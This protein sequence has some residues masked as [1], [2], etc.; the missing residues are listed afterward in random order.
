MPFTP[1]QQQDLDETFNEYFASADFSLSKVNLHVKQ[2]FWTFDNRNTIDG[3]TRPESRDE[4]VNT[5]VSTI[6]GNTQLGERWDLSAGYT[7]A[8]SDGRADLETTPGFVTP[9]KHL[10]LRHPHCRDGV[11]P[12][13]DQRPAGSPG[14]P[15]SHPE[16]GRQRRE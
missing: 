10:Y 9:Q 3:P 8:H 5:Y 6:K 16:T 14:L 4:N 15:V 12:S 11:E 1:S 2:S 13:A 7:Y